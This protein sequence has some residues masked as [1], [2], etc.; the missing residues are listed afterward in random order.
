MN[1]RWLLVA[2]ALSFAAPAFAQEKKELRWGTDPTGG[3][4]YVYQDSQG[5]FIGF[6]YEFA[7]YLAKKLGRESVKVDGDWSTLPE[8]LE[9]P[10]VGEKGIDIV[11][12]GYEKRDDL[13]AKYGM[14]IPYYTYRL[15]LVAHKDADDIKSW[16]DLTKPGPKGKRK[17]GVLEGSVA[18]DYARRLYGD[19]VEVLESKDVAIM[20]EE[21]KRRRRIDATIQDTPASVY[22]TR[23][24]PEL[25]LVGEGRQPSFYVIYLRKDDEE[26]RNELDAAIKEGLK[27]GT[28]Q[29]IYSKYGLWNADQEWMCFNQTGVFPTPLDDIQVTEKTDDKANPWPRLLRELLRSRGHDDPACRRVIP[30]RD[31]RGHADRRWPRLWARL[32]EV[33]SRGV[34][35]SDP[36]HAAHAATLLSLLH[37]SEVCSRA[38]A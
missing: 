9:K 3:A 1:P 16:A 8:L 14:T 22:F 12:N 38:H 6:E 32:G 24:M 30:A 25:K 26:L 27:D 28:L 29:R 4:P 21:V 15:Q 35:R 34:C 20:F 36:R 37:A 10:R 17:V 13:D 7:Q 33:P 19:Q 2:I 23:V 11:L 5:S 31:G 18:A